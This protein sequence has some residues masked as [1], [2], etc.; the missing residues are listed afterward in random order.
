MIRLVALLGNPGGEHARNRHNVAWHFADAVSPWSALSWQKK[1]KG[2]HAAWEGP[3]GR[4]V[5]LE[6]D[7]YMN[8]SGD[9]IAAAMDFFRVAPDELLV[10]HDELEMRFG[11]FGFKK[12]GGLGGHNGLRSTKAR[13]GTP[14]FY[15]LRFGIGR[16]DHDDVA[17]Y[18]LSNFAPEERDALDRLVF[19]KAADA[20]G[21]ALVDIDAAIASMPKVDGLADSR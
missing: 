3:A 1:F 17:G 11:L 12:G 16:P 7:T 13:L 21:K 10:V 4:V 18:V 19:P 14:D 6:P 5:L 15:R 8:L 9:S 2:R 20:L